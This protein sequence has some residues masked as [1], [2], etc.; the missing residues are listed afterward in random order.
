MQDADGAQ[1]LLRITKRERAISRA[2]NFAYQKKLFALG[3]AMPEPVEAGKC[4][5]GAYTLERFLPGEDAR[6]ALPIPPKEEQYALGLEAGRILR[7]I[8]SVPAPEGTPDWEERFNRKIDRKIALYRD[9]PIRFEGDSRVLSYLAQNR[10][11]LADR[12]QSLQH[13]DYHLGNMMLCGKTLCVIDFDRLD[14][15]DPEEEFNRI[16]WCAAASPEFASGRIDGYFEEAKIPEEFWR[17]MLLYIAS[18]TLSS[19]PWAI[20]FGEGEIE[21]MKRQARDVLEFSQGFTRPVP[22]WYCGKKA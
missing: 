1:Y 9:C 6:Q 12:P 11:L 15:G 10:S 2:E 14:F 4:E 3:V 18:N 7:L 20:P 13:G 5:E 22:L 16:V 17:R 8:H 19:I 21:T